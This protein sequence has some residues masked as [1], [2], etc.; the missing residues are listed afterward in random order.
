MNDIFNG[1]KRNPKQ[2][3]PNQISREWSVTHSYYFTFLRWL[4]SDWYCKMPKEDEPVSFT[5]TN[6]ETAAGNN[7]ATGSAMMDL[8]SGLQK[9][10]EADRATGGGSST[11]ASTSSGK[12]K[13]KKKKS[14][15]KRKRRKDRY[16]SQNYLLR[17]EGVLCCA[18][19]VVAFIFVVALFIVFL[20]CGIWSKFDFSATTESVKE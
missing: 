18:S 8:I 2:S 14:K 6:A 9:K 5:D 16:E 13:K 17:I 11:S 15:Y 12:R 7:K 4:W 19:L 10:Q 20:I 1:K 3:V